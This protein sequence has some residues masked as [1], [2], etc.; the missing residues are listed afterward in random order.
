MRIYNVYILFIH[1]QKLT[2]GSFHISEGG[3][4]MMM[5]SIMTSAAFPSWIIIACE[6][7]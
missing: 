1:R 4:K 6:H 2:D 3:L 5:V 7:R